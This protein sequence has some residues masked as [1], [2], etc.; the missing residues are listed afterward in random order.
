M[1]GVV[2]HRR[3]RRA[4]IRQGQASGQ[5][6]EERRAELLFQQLDVMADGA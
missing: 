3:Q 1:K 4:F 6:A 5:P 2:Q